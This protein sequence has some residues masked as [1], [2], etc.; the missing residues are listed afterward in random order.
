MNNHVEHHLYPQV[1]FHALPKLRDAVA[2]QVPAP[3]PGFFRTNRE[4]LTVVIRR[5]LG[6][7]TRARSI[8]QAPHMISEGAFAPSAQRT[9]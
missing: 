6:R 7:N 4:V 1:P 8:R 5:S 9:M 2:D 3:D